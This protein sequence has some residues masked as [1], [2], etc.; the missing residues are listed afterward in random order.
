[1]GGGIVA[2]PEISMV[3]KV[4]KFYPGRASIGPILDL[5]ITLLSM[6]KVQLLNL[7]FFFSFSFE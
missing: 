6:G 7:G 3:S 5:F 4:G 1:V 2:S